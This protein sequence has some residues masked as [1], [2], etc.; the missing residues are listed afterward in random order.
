MEISI[1]FAKN[2]F[3]MNRF[4]IDLMKNVSGALKNLENAKGFKIGEN[5]HHLLSEVDK[6]HSRV[7][8]IQ[9]S[10]TRTVEQL[11]QIRIY[12]NRYPFKKYYF[13][14]GISQLEYIQYHTEVL[15]HKVHT[16]LEIMKL[17]I[18]EVYQLG[19]AP[20]DCSWVALVKKIPL[21]SG[22]MKNLDH[23]FK[24]FEDLIDRRHSNTHRGYYE[25]QEKDDIDMK[26]GLAFYRLEME[27]HRIDEEL[28]DS[29]PMPLIN[30]M[31]R[32]H[33]KK[34]VELIDTCI[35]ENE[36]LLTAFLDSLFDEYQKQIL[37]FS[38][39]NTTQ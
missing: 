20:K 18:N 39:V 16:I 29:M 35:T 19:I 12:L 31:L 22:P 9:S 30:Y 27:G 36:K 32:E 1:K 38:I 14:K 3:L 24:T 23:Y 8:R 11:G 26:Y 10:L 34:R 15:F 33:K 17:L 6:Y 13:E 21:K 25:D 28:K 4:S 7:F 5:N 37:H 2:N